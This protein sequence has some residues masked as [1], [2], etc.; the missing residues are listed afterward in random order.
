M[1]PNARSVGQWL[2]HGWAIP[3]SYVV[4]FFIMLAVWGWQPE[5]SYPKVSLRWAKGEIARHRH[6]LP[7][8]AL[9]FF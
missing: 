8:R 7:D 6:A 5:T 4:S 9:M 3:L 2:R 1:Y